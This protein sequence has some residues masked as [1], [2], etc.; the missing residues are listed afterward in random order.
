MTCAGGASDDRCSDCYLGRSFFASGCPTVNMYVA[1]SKIRG[2]LGWKQTLAHEL[3]HQ[4]IFRSGHHEQLSE[5]RE[6]KIINRFIAEY[7]AAI[8]SGR[9]AP[10]A[11]R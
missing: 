2:S 11:Q 5:R 4:L 8:E 9:A 7:G 1:Y 10:Q 6:H 3:L